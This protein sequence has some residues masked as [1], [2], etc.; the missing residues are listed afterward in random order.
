M[1]LLRKLALITALVAISASAQGYKDLPVRTINGTAYHVYEV[2]PKE[3][4]YS[5]TRQWGITRQQL[6]EWNPQVADGLRAGELLLFPVEV[7]TEIIP[8]VEI[9][10]N[11]P[12]NLENRDNR[13]KSDDAIN[14][15]VIL[16]FKLEAEASTKAME[17]VT[18]FYRGFMLGIDSLATKAG[19]HINVSAFDSD[20]SAA[21]VAQIM[22]KP[23]MLQMDYIIAPD[24]AESIEAIAKVA[25]KTD[26]LVLNLFAVKS[27]A[28]KQHESLMQTMIPH[29]LMYDRA[30]AAFCRENAGRKV[31][32]LNATDIPAEKKDFTTALTKALVKAGI[33]Y[34]T[35][36]YEGKLDLER[37][38]SLPLG[39]DYVLVPT[40][41]SRESFMRIMQ[42]AK[43][44]KTSRAADRITLFG[45]PEWVVFP[46]NL[47]NEMHSIDTTIYSRFSTDLDAPGAKQVA[48]SYRTAFN[49][50]LEKETPVSALT[51]FDA[52]AWIINAAANGISDPFS[53]VQY[54][55]AIEQ[56]ENQGG[57]NSALYF[58]HFTPGGSVDATVK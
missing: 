47:K 54:S 43:E 21:K 2:K 25:D 52:A 57:V 41:S 46:A 10:Q 18:N 28:W 16:P 48:R 51:G 30:I 55:F 35:I 37:L 44:F 20:G 12:E 9:I 26:G 3:T 15:A 6:I 36:D 19:A 24:D 17:N 39:K 42:T 5:L 7:K 23:E 40:S 58:I 49:K 4:V 53:G 13:D 45:Y 32:L 34:E 8:A 14:I 38:T 29:S 1:N 56:Q 11:K 27:D 31:I 22:S 33:P 50:P